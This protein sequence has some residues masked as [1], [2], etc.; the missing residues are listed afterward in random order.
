MHLNNSIFKL[1]ENKSEFFA[2]AIAFSIHYLSSASPKL[3]IL[4]N[5]SPLHSFK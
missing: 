5:N 4:S 2:Q 3:I 1:K